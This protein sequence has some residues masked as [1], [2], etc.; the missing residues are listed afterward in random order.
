MAAE[1]TEGEVSIGAIMQMG[2]AIGGAALSMLMHTMLESRMPLDLCALCTGN[3]LLFARRW[4]GFGACFC[5]FSRP[6]TN[7]TSTSVAAVACCCRANASN[8]PPHD[9]GALAS[10]SAYSSIAG[11]AGARVVSKALRRAVCTLP[12]SESVV[13]ILFVWC[14][15]VPKGGACVENHSLKKPDHVQC[16]LLV[17]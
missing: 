1:A 17:H 10:R 4:H 7:A 13:T 2:G 12:A 11:L 16:L 8:V 9:A 5:C 14:E 15:R 3:G 6:T